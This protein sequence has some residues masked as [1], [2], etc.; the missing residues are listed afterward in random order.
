MS[1]YIKKTAILFCIISLLA[2]CFSACSKEEDKNN[3]K[4]TTS[5]DTLTSGSLDKLNSGEKIESSDDAG[6]VND[7]ENSEKNDSIEQVGD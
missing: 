2:V 3:P 4:P 5:S 1:I 7:T 6:L